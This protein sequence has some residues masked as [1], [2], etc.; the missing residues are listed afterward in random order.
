MNDDLVFHHITPQQIEIH[1]QE[2][3]LQTLEDIPVFRDV[4]VFRSIDTRYDLEALVVTESDESF[5]MICEVKSKGEPHYVRKAA[6]QLLN[7]KK[8]LQDKG[9]ECYC[10]IG[11][12]YI[13]E[14]SSNICEELG[15][16]FIDLSGNCK[17][18]YKSLYISVEGK[19][20]KYKEKRARSSIFERSSVKSSI[21]LRNLLSDPL[22]QWKGQELADISSC[23]T[24]QISKVKK[25]LV[26]REYAIEGGQGFFVSKPKE[27]IREWAK[28]YHSKPN[29][30]Y[31]CYAL[32]AIPRIEQKLAEMK[33]KTGIEY[34]LTGFSGGVR[35]APTVRYNKVHVYI[36]MQDFP[37]A[38]ELL[39][40]KRVDSGSNLTII[41]PYDPCVMLDV[42]NINGNQVASPVQVCL[43][44]LGLKGRGE[45]AAYAI[46][47]KEFSK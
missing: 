22:K 6:Q 13:S 27:I 37:E 7:I 16:G 15:I 30:V 25:Y 46:L 45:E 28:V 4:N 20:N 31:D 14:A 32:D 9:H 8:N 5:Y 17:I 26:E 2:K 47:D 18:H 1:I 36:P 44:L 39:G 43:D 33:E 3:L 10:L 12:P 24:G 34:A 35:Y 29:T 41:V 23:S 40:C 19:P 21:I 42:R 38:I 11:A